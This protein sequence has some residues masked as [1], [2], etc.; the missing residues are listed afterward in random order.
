GA[1]AL[2]KPL[3][4]R[5]GGEPLR[6]RAVSAG[7]QGSVSRGPESR[8]EPDRGQGCHLRVDQGV[9]REGKMN[10]PAHLDRLRREIRGYAVDYGLDFFE[11]IFEVLDY[12]RMNEV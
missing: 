3:R 5:P 11:V 8:R 4:L 9:P 6:D 2:R 7:R 10:L 12:D 1:A